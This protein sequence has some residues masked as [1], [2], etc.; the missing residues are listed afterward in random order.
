V[1]TQGLAPVA[2]GNVGPLGLGGGAVKQSRSG[3]GAVD[4]S[5]LPM[6]E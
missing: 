5:H 1:A 2:S 4:N 3:D 6:G